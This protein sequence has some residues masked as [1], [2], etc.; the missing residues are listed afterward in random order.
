[1]RI[2]IDLGGTKIEGAVLGDDGTIRARERHATPRGDYDAT[3]RLICEI[4]RSLGAR[5]GGPAPIG[6][7]MPGTLCPSSHVVK[8][9]NSTLAAHV[10]SPIVTTRILPPVH[11]DSSG[12]RGAAWLWPLRA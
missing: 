11:G 6:I 7:G 12:V 1:M 10:F 8:N 2:G 9:A 4:A 5:L 3:L